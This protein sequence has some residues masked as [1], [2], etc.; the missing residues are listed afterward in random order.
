MSTWHESMTSSTCNSIPTI[1]CGSPSQNNIQFHRET[2]PT[3]TLFR[4][5]TLYPGPPTHRLCTC[6]CWNCL[7]PVKNIWTFQNFLHWNKSS[8][9]AEASVGD[10]QRRLDDTGVRY[11][12]S[13]LLPQDTAITSRL[14]HA[15][16]YP[17]TA[18]YCSTISFALTFV[19]VSGSD[20]RTETLLWP[21]K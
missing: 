16:K 15:P 13:L 14:Q 3:E 19:I 18:R 2:G 17:I 9:A 6:L 1:D 4:L 8:I 20:G 11:L 7:A 10:P 21:A 12:V 5:I